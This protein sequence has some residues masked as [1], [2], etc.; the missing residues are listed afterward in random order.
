MMYAP[1]NIEIE[2]DSSAY[3][4]KMAQAI[5]EISQ[6]SG[7]L[8]LELV[9][10][11]G[12]VEEVVKSHNNQTE[13]LINLSSTTQDISRQNLVMSER[14]RDAEQIIKHSA[15]D[16]DKRITHAT[17]AM[18]TWA[19]SAQESA[20]RVN[21][22]ARLLDDVNQIA[23]SIEAIASNI[24]L[25]A[26]NA[27]I[28]AARAGE[29]GRGFAVVA[30]EVK[31]LS[32]R[33]K[34]SSVHIQSTV[35][36]LTSEISSLKNSSQEDLILAK[37]MSGEMGD[38]GESLEGLRQSFNNIQNIVSEIS[39]NAA[40]NASSTEGLVNELNKLTGDVKTVDNLMVDAGKR[41]E[42]VSE[43]SEKIMQ[44]V[45]SAGGA[46]VDSEFISYATDTA[47]KL[48]VI[49][50]NAIANGEISANDAFD[51]DYVEITGTNPVQHRTKF[52]ALTDKYFTEIQ[53]EI[54]GRNSEIV[55]CAAI[56]RNGYLPTH[57]KKFS[58]P[59]KAGD[60]VWNAAN[61]RN[62]RI[63]NDKVGLKSGKNQGEPLVQAYRRDMGNGNYVMMKDIS[64]PI[65]VDGRH[66]GGLRIGIKA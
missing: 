28:E 59:Q 11:S 27:N 47:T 25:L 45:S 4:H 60:V 32:N 7:S 39:D 30:A 14:L 40:Y 26:L 9:S 42:G 49:L 1:N 12:A 50:E 24:N 34:E 13:T 5:H 61:C 46:S 58:L 38:A 10:V 6:I 63:F 54:L 41:L 33:T 53:E 31:T 21:E 57:N 35:G 55:F 48:A 16:T 20:D 29:A 64:A 52:L 36:L 62:R 66:W 8:G 18:N 19:N 3:D 17:E 15:I 43:V 23:K 37:T 65:F 2:A 22:L 51:T 44:I 56:D